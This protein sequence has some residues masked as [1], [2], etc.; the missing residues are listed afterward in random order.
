MESNQKSRNK[1]IYLWIPG[2]FIRKPKHTLEKNKTT[3]ST[4]NSA[5]QAGE[6]L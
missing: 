1:S 6:L 4:T 3:F 2:F 5:A